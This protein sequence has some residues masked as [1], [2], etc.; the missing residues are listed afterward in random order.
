MNNTPAANS[1]E[2]LQAMKDLHKKLST[3]EK[4]KNKLGNKLA[5]FIS[6]EIRLKKAHRTQL[7]EMIEQYKFLSNELLLKH[8][9]FLKLSNQ[10]DLLIAKVGFTPSKGSYETKLESVRNKLINTH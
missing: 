10:H 8:R 5:V 3:I 2:L 9:D 4:Q 6:S 7:N 1:K